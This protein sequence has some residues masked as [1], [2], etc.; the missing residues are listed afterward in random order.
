[1]ADGPV[2]HGIGRWLALAL[3]VIVIDQASKAL[4]LARFVEGETVPVLP[5]F[6]LVL[7]YNPGAAFSFL[8]G[9][10]GWQRGLFTLIALVASI[11]IV[12]MLRRQRG[13][14]MASLAL[15]LILGGALGNLIDRLWLGKVVDFLLFHLGGAAFP[16]FNAADSAITLGAVLL[17][18]DSLRGPRGDGSAGKPPDSPAPRP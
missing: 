3:A 15:A 5:V 17:V 9:A 13:Q 11:V 16:A 4:I 7:A 12:A 2:R 14:W 6:S 1:V 8:A 10:G 18:V